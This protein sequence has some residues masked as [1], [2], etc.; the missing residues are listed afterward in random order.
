MRYCSIPKKFDVR[1]NTIPERVEIASGH[2]EGRQNL[3]AS[4]HRER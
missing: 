3:C 2:K 4:L 1:N